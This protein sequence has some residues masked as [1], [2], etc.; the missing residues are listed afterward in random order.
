METKTKGLLLPIPVPASTTSILIP[1]NKCVNFSPP[2]R[3]K[4][5]GREREKQ[6]VTHKLPLFPIK[7]VVV[8]GREYVL[9]PWNIHYKCSKCT[10]T[11]VLYYYFM[12]G[13]EN[14]R[15]REEEQPGT[16]YNYN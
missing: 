14:K 3:E 8:C 10:H 1:N 7:L 4:R 11:P 16:A 15:K 9:D 5:E 13:R 6:R 12:R 2:N